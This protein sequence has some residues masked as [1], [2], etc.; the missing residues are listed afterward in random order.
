MENISN[1]PSVCNID[2]LYPTLFT[3]IR[4]SI[5]IM[6][7]ARMHHQINHKWVV[8]LFSNLF[9]VTIE[10]TIRSFHHLMA[11]TRSIKTCE[12][13]MRIFLL[14]SKWKTLTRNAQIVKWQ[15]PSYP[16]N[17]RS[18]RFKSFPFGSTIKALIFLYWTLFQYFT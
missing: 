10:M 1:N 7:M 8:V 11:N 14:D 12:I 16:N 6:E 18:I 13:N 9:I 4:Q 3:I 17:M 5:Q 2:N 15:P